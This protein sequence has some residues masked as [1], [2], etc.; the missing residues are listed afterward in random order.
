MNIAF[1]VANSLFTLYMLAILLRWLGP[2]LSLEVESGRLRWIARL[3]DP[4]VNRI[5]RLLPPM[6]PVDIGPFVALMAIWFVREIAKGVLAGPPG[7]L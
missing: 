7:G 5:R 1:R 6:G 3:T 2:W 4:L